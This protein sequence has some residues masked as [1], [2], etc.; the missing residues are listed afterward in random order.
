MSTD[1]A[2]IDSGHTA[3]VLVAMALVQ[4]ML[5]GLAFFYAG[6]LPKTSV[7]TMIMQNYIS[8]GI[9]FILWF[10]CGFSLCFGESYDLWGSITRFPFFSNVDGGALQQKDG[11]TF[12]SDIPG[13]VFAAYQGMFAVITPALMT[14]AF[15]DR[16]L[17][18]PYC[19]F[20]AI[21]IIVV[22]CPFCHWVWGPDGWMGGW[23]VKDFAGGIVVHTTAGFSALA[24]VH[25]LGA[26]PN[27]AQAPAAK[28]NPSPGA[29]EAAHWQTKGADTPK[30]EGAQLE[31]HEHYAMTSG[32]SVSPAQFTTTA[33][34]DP[35]IAPTSASQEPHSVPM[36]ALGT[37]LLWFGWFGFNGGSALASSGQAA[38]AAV[39]TEIAAA[40]ALCVWV[41]IEWFVD[42]RPTL[43]GLCVG[44]V[45]GLATVTPASGFIK[46][47]AACL[48]GVLASLFCYGCVT[49]ATH[50]KWDDALDVWGVHGMGGA[51]GSVLLGA[52]AD[53]SVGGVSASMELVGKQ[54]AAVAFCA[55]YSYIVT[56]VILKGLSYC[57]ALKPTRE[58]M[59][60]MDASVY[61]EVAYGDAE[62]SGSM[63]TS[64]KQSTRD[65]RAGYEN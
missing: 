38:Y 10:I 20:I 12:V 37:G 17:L 44:A 21:W 54:L 28:S 16:L 48:I 52:F 57:M 39:N 60:D 31:P 15:A 36:V 56:L 19:L 41:V 55:A 47:W 46:P 53:E 58:Q 35:N 33:A 64:G 14:G 22:Y 32:T 18:A 6:L 51:L 11:S 63:T 5:P 4:L 62:M 1:S 26:R 27:Q 45:A 7:V 61:G 3:W 2:S 13:L 8:M 23:G 24:A 34:P 29:L 43:V 9:V 42:G 49:T 40:T 30:A 59:D 50:R 65:I 25:Y